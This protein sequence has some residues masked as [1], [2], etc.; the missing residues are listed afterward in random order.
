MPSPPH[1]KIQTCV[2]CDRSFRVFWK[3]QKGRAE[4]R[5]CEMCAAR[6]WNAQL[7]RAN[8]IQLH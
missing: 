1:F 3:W 2:R 8:R 6:R 5:V 4:L 7:L